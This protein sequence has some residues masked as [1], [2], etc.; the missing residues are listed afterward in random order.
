[1]WTY[2]TEKTSGYNY[3]TTAVCRRINQLTRKNNSDPIKRLQTSHY[4]RVEF[5]YCYL[6]YVAVD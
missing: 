5:G 2:K 6:E 3:P 4:K 1:M